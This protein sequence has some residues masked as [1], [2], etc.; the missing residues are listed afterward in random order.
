MSTASKVTLGVSISFTIGMITYVHMWQKKERERLR[1]GVV[2]D[3]ERQQR[4]QANRR[5]QEQ[6]A[7]LTKLLQQ[8]QQMDQ[9]R[10][11]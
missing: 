6:Q 1:E 2:M 8:Q 7:E 4:K 3:L 5:D 10:T 11:S 9:Q